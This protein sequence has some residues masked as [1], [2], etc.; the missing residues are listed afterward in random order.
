MPGEPKQQNK[1]RDETHEIPGSSSSI[2]T[3]KIP[4]RF[5]HNISS[6]DNKALCDRDPPTPIMKQ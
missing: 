4:K 1:P 6:E 5:Q 2:V 3:I